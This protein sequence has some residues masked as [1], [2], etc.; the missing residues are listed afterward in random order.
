MKPF[1]LEKAKR[2]EP[3]VC[4]DG[5]PAKFIAHVPEAEE[6]SR[7]VVLIDGEVCMTYDGGGGTRVFVGDR[8]DLFMAPVKRTVWLNL[9]STD[10]NNA[11]MYDDEKTADMYA[12][13]P[14][15]IGGRAWPLEIE[16]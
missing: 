5:T 2:G 6:Y 12:N 13:K 16:E 10:Y 14:V 4:R 15:R 11:V 3:I 8:R 7:L 9:Y 1:D